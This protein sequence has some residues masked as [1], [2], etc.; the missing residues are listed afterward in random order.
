M[1]IKD[2][3]IEEMTGYKPFTTFYQDFGIAEKFG[4]KA[5]KNTF[6]IGIT[7]GYKTLTEFVMVLNWKIWEHYQSNETLARF[8]N[9]LWEQARE[10][11]T[12]TLKDEALSYYYKTTD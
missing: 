3:N 5:I 4:Y 2:W 9:D 11:A 8:Y 1:N 7:G 6:D 10:H 12:S